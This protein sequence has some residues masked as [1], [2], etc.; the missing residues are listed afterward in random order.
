MKTKQTVLGRGSKACPAQVSRPGCQQCP[1]RAAAPRGPPP[2]PGDAPLHC[3]P[4]GRAA[5]PCRC[6]AP[7]CTGRP[8]PPRPAGART[9]PASVWFACPRARPEFPSGDPSGCA[10]SHIGLLQ[11]PPPPQPEQL[12][13]GRPSSPARRGDAPGPLDPRGHWDP[14]DMDA[15]GPKTPG[16]DALGHAVSGV[17]PFPPPRA[18]H[19]PRAGLRARPGWAGRGFLGR[20][21]PPAPASLSRRTPSR[22]DARLAAG[23]G[24]PL[25]TRREGRARPQ[26]R[27]VRS[28][29]G[30][31]GLP[32]PAPEPAGLGLAPVTAPAP[33]RPV[34]TGQGGR[35]RC[36]VRPPPP[37]SWGRSPASPPPAQA[38][39][40]EPALAGREQGGSLGLAS[41]WARLVPAGPHRFSRAQSPGHCQNPTIGGRFHSRALQ[42]PPSRANTFREGR[43]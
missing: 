23:A 42:G 9:S 15:R 24:P 39:A 22:R 25:P 34:D 37:R 4:E 1:G 11:V 30:P 13:T 41:R 20:P 14:L 21:P 16:G 29:D 3:L 32:V 38:A 28:P 43:R 19:P 33:L 2:A 6:T 27:R 10:A 8:L 12:A 7:P 5:R 17:P 26:G 40:P 36:S 31:P 18:P 35:G